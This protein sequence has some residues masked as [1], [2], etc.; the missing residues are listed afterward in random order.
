MHTIGGLCSAYSVGLAYEQLV[1]KVLA[2]YGFQ[3]MHTGGPGDEGQDFN[4][5]WLLPHKKI[6]VIGKTTPSVCDYLQYS[7]SVQVSWSSCGA[8]WSERMGGCYPQTV[9]VRNITIHQQLYWRHG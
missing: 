2:R 6:P 9:L 8:S 4:G 1:L 7:R 3:L 5:L